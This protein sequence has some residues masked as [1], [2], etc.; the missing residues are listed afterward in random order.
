MIALN[1][2]ESHLRS[3]KVREMERI[4]HGDTL[5]I[6][7]FMSSEFKKAVLDK[8]GEIVFLTG[9][10]RMGEGAWV[11]IIAS[12]LISENPIASLEMLIRLHD[13]GRDVLGCKFSY[14]FN[15]PDFPFAVRF[16]E[17][18]GYVERGRKDL[19]D[20]VERLL[21]VREYKDGL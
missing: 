7:D 11:W 21:M 17:R 4:E 18:I 14:T 13:E 9:G 8:N 10:K 16:L 2:Q 6:D 5:P 15:H 19:G 3:I 12:D 1:L 20:G